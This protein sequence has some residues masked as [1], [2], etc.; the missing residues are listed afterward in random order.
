MKLKEVRESALALP[1]R[2]RMKLVNDL[3]KSLMDKSVPGSERPEAE[4]E[5]EIKR[6][7]EAHDRGEAETV[8]G[9]EILEWLRQRM[10]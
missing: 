5:E 6:R 8:P 1:E 10:K 3:I 9:D 4:W 7:L 2:S